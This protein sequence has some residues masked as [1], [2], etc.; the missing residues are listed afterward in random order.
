MKGK[1]VYCCC[2]NTASGMEETAATPLMNVFLRYSCFLYTTISLNSGI[3]RL[4]N[5]STSYAHIS[6]FQSLQLISKG[7]GT[8]M[9]R[10]TQLRHMD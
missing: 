2:P 7:M 8:F 1:R 9:D 5:E 6:Q 4:L 3:P 10:Q